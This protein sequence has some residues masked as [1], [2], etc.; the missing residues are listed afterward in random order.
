MKNYALLIV[1]SIVLALILSSC[2]KFVPPKPQIP[3]NLKVI[4][5]TSNTI[6]ISWSEDN[7]SN[8]VSFEVWHSM[9][10]SD[11]TL[12]AT[13]SSDNY[14]DINLSPN[15]MY[16]YKVRA[17]NDGGYSNFSNVI[18]QKTKDVSPIAPSNL[19]VSSYST[20]T[21]TLSWNDNSNNETGFEIW[22]SLDGYSFSKIKDLSANTTSYTD[23]GLSPDTTYYYKVRAYNDVGYSSY[24]NMAYQTTDTVITIPT[25][26]TNLK[27]TG[28]DS[29][30]IS[31]RWD[32]NSDNEDGFKIYRSSSYYGT[33]SLIG[34]NI[35]DD[36]YY[37]DKGLDSNTTYYYKVTAY[38]SAGESSY[39]NIVSGTT[40]AP[41]YAH[42][43][44]LQTNSYVDSIGYLNVIGVVQNDGTEN[45]KYVEIDATFYDKNNNVVGS[46]FTYTYMDILTPGQK[47]P[48]DVFIS[49]PANY[50]HY[51]LSLSYEE[52]TDEP[53]Q[54]L[55]IQGVT[56]HTDN[57]GYYYIDGEVKNT[58]TTKAKYVEVVATL[59]DSTGKIVYAKFTYTNSDISYGQT[60]SFEVIVN[61]SEVPGNIVSFDLQVQASD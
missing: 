53:F 32:D 9:D 28:S 42:A 36:N 12:A 18:S 6:S 35:D 54:G 27:V 60:S 55:K 43:K 41:S 51:K 47:S 45:L 4:S 11:F 26:P 22:R 5:Y 57:Y 3:T 24:S 31:L 61:T 52:T 23:I 8:N 34:T 10:G 50:D 19:Y 56:H 29:D 59:Y 16:Y 17:H 49:K 13:T 25:A 58:N 20:N 46:N 1:F 14:T 37:T 15:T 40:S 21:I 7:S 38:N 39:S 48:F 30:S 33:Y 2:L 44:I